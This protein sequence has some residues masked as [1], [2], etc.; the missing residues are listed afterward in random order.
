MTEA[1]SRLVR[2]L[3]SQ[4]VAV[5]T[6]ELL[7]AVA[8]SNV[9][10]LSDRDRVS[11]ALRATLAKSPRARRVFDAAF[12]TVFAS[13]RVRR[14]N[15][16]RGAADSGVGGSRDPEQEGSAGGPD[17]D[18]ATRATGSRNPFPR[19]PRHGA[20]PPFRARAVDRPGRAGRGPRVI[21]DGSRAEPAR[22]AATREGSRE[23]PADGSLGAAPRPTSTAFP[24]RPSSDDERR[25]AAAAAALVSS[26]RSRRARR[27]RKARQ[28]RL[29][30]SRLLRTAAATG[31]VPFRLPMRRP[32][33]SRS[34]VRLIVDVS[35]STATAT[36]FF[37]RM[38]LALVEPGPRCR[39][40][41]F[42]DSPV[43]VTE[44]LRRVAGAG[45]FRL[46][47]FLDEVPELDPG[48]ASDYG[49][50]WY[51]LAK[52]RPGRGTLLVVLGDARVNRNDPLAWA[53]HELAAS[54]RGVVWLVPEA[55]ER[56]GAGDSALEA[57][58]SSIDVLVEAIDLEGLARGIAAIDRG[59]VR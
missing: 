3:R 56:W 5:G 16:R 2:L 36:D 52:R 25:L 7:D 12:A 44:R 27:L 38:A 29:C 35:H 14:P 34:D 17:R 1:L 13:P 26:M 41:L 8:A 15:E 39:V 47:T 45:T 19:F 22:A 42:V 6:A 30:G 24:R 40:E 4:G 57:Y 20:N 31:G 10:D 51:R 32:R 37:L 49:R 53:F 58:A 33:P 11:L 9:V 59:R 21:L 48:G 55:C 46:D 50:M 28:G 18:D 54:C 43:D 23:V